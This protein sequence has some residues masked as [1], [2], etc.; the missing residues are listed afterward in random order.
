MKILL[1]KAHL[2]WLFANDTEQWERTCS[3]V[4]ECFF[5]ATKAQHSLDCFFYHV[6]SAPVVSHV[7]RAMAFLKGLFIKINSRL[8]SYFSFSNGF[9][10][11]GFPVA[12]I[13]LYNFSLFFRYNVATAKLYSERVIE[14][15]KVKMKGEEDLHLT[16]RIEKYVRDTGVIFCANKQLSITY[17]VTSTN[18]TF[19]VE[20]YFC[21][22][23]RPG[24]CSTVDGQH[25][26]WY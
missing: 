5:P 19:C 25:S 13:F 12:T 9:Q 3:R 8:P 1:Q 26:N 15:F 20:H 24:A 21:G 11:M 4:V 18:C 7:G 2:P 16:D 17:S 23:P 6:H 22:I 10:I 14:N